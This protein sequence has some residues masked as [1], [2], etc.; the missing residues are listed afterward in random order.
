MLKSLPRTTLAL[1]VILI[2]LGIAAYLGTGRSSITALIPAFL[3]IAL[4]GLGALALAKPGARK[5][6]MHAAV[7]VALLGLIGS[8]MRPMR[9]LFS[10]ESLVFNTPVIMQLTTAGLCLIFIAL[11]VTSFLAARSSSDPR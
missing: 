7:V 2:I 10:D 4:A 1:G 5:H 6:A 9:T 3:G 11:S 8:L